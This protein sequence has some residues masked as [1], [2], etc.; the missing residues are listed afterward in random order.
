M[1]LSA[2]SLRGQSMRRPNFST[3]RGLDQQASGYGIPALEYSI[4][5]RSE[6]GRDEVDTGHDSNEHSRAGGE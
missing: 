4:K 3:I 6:S 5:T 2:C 1:K